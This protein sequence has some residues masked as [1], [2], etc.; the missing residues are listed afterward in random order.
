MPD[1]ENQGLTR[2]ASILVHAF[3]TLDALVTCLHENN[4]W[5][6][7]WYQEEHADVC[8]MHCSID[9]RSLD[10]VFALSNED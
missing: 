4:S 10:V 9:L 5:Q 1:L 6:C 8:D 2:I 7:Q 3:L